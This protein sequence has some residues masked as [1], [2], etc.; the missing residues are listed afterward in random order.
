MAGNVNPQK[1]PTLNI[2]NGDSA[3]TIMQKAGLP[4]AE[5]R[6]RPGELF[7]A[8]QASEERRFMGDVV[9][10][11]ILNQFLQSD[12]PLLSLPTGSK[13]LTLPVTPDQ[14]LSI[15]QTGLAVL[16]GDLNWLEIHDLD[17]WIGGVHLTGENSW[18]WDAAN[19]KLIK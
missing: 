3:V 18:C 9:F 1:K 10:W 4:V 11:D 16:N 7:G 14:R 8:Y 13:A 15:T 17:C 12:P 2:T 6:Q 19:A 5:G